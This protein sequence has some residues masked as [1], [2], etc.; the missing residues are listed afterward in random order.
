MS[1]W[2]KTWNS[3]LAGI[4]K[5]ELKLNFMNLSTFTSRYLH[6]VII[7]TREKC[8][9]S[10]KWA[11]RSGKGLSSR[12]VIQ[13]S[14]PSTTSQLFFSFCSH[15][16][17]ENIR[18]IK[19][20]S[21]LSSEPFLLY[22]CLRLV[23]LDQGEVLVRVS[24]LRLYILFYYENKIVAEIRKR[25]LKHH[26]RNRQLE[27]EWNRIWFCW[28]MRP[29][30]RQENSLWIKI[31]ISRV[32]KLIRSHKVGKLLCYPG[33][34][35]RLGRRLISFSWNL[36][37]TLSLSLLLLQPVSDDEEK[38]WKSSSSLLSAHTLQQ[39]TTT[40]FDSGFP[41]FCSLEDVHFEKLAEI[42]DESHN[43]KKKVNKPSLSISSQ[44][45]HQIHLLDDKLY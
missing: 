27:N 19:N 9:E 41:L 37:S 23:S 5:N 3:K 35:W 38:L 18:K 28:E 8:R 22:A 13:H 6:H 29:I 11:R 33:L 36:R 34:V 42:S 1:A 45:L 31:L 2:K 32:S 43:I 24:T 12:L 30:M 44:N 15:N 10:E 16:F 26:G 14:H 7:K 39:L 17:S 25:R 20:F 21:L 4:A 40:I